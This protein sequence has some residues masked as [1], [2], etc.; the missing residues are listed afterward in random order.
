VEERRDEGESG[1]SLLEKI[2]GSKRKE[3]E[4]LRHESWPLAA[5]KPIDV[6]RAL[7]RPTG[8]ALRLVAEVKRKSPSGGALST[9]LSAAARA[10]A[11]S[12]HG[13]AMVSVL[14]DAPF[15]DGG[16]SHLAD[17]RV[18]CDAAGLGT[19]LLAKEF[20]LDEAQIARARAA[21]ADAVLLIARI[22]TPER[23]RE[24]AEAVRLAGLEPL[25]EVV[26]ER[27]LDAA[28]AAGAR[29][30]GVNARDLDTLVMDADRAARVVAAIPRGIVAVHLSGV[31]TADDVRSIAAGRADAA[32]IGEVLMRADD[33]APL[34]DELVKA[35]GRS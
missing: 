9:V 23:L 11:Y 14:C 31:R 7:D 3:I 27:E 24:L 32:L 25:L 20:V 22:V 26:D 34:L 30:V 12:T 17:A 21:G 18:A 5:R 6:A 28:L 29:V 35:S 8:G 16:W 33:P 1:M 10:V 19:P 13:A 2:L 15:F 4:A